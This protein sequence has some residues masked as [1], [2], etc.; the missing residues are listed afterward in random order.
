MILNVTSNTDLSRVGLIAILAGVNFCAR[1]SAPHAIAFSI[2][3][4][5]GEVSIILSAVTSST[6]KSVGFP[7]PPSLPYHSLA[8]IF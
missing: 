5:T 1:L 7:L 2:K 3:L 8:L 4:N 6:S